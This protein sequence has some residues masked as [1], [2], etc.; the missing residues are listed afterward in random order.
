MEPSKNNIRGAD[1]MIGLTPRE[2]WIAAQMKW[3]GGWEDIA[4]NVQEPRI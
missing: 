2:N 3:L 4:N 1:Q